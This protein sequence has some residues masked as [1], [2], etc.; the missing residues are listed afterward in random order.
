MIFFGRKATKIGELNISHAKCP[1]C[2]NTDTQHVTVFGKYFH[3]YWIPFFPI[4]K[5]AVAECTH[6]M[7]TISQKEFPQNLKNRYEQS[8][9]Q[10][11]RPVWHWAGLGVIGALIVLIGIIDATAEVDPRHELL[12]ADIEQLSVNP[13][14]ETDSISYKL[15][16]FFNDF[17]N[18]A[19]NPSE[20][21]FLTKTKE[22]MALI[23]VK[24]PN[25]KKVEKEGRKDV[26]EMIELIAESQESIK[27]MDKYIGVHGKYN[28][29]MVKT[30]D[31][32]ANGSI[33]SEQGLYEFYGPKVDGEE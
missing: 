24:I 1:H 3:I 19:I 8:R 4:G 13:T 18:E 11:K 9:D 16:A 6:C 33:V 26:I 21:E 10:I 20:F 7:R 23:L 2:E 32:F 30:P 22:N 5:E 15:K 14:M 31:E 17:A 25:L 27:D 29:M 12:K 28:M